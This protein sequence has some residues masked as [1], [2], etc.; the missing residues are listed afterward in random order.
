MKNNKSL[1]WGLIGLAV[2]ILVALYAY[3]ED[4]KRRLAE[5][6]TTEEQKAATPE[7]TEETE[8]AVIPAEQPADETAAA[9]E[10]SAAD[11]T[12]SST[13]DTGDTDS[14]AASTD[15]AEPDETDSTAAQTEAADETDKAEDTLADSDAAETAAASAAPAEP[16]AAPQ[17]D[18]V[19]VEPDGSTVIAG[20]AK[21][22]ATVEVVT[23]DR[24]L[25]ESEV[26]QSG[27]FAAIFDDP[28]APGDYEI[29]LRV[30]EEGDV[31]AQSEEVA[32]V[33][34]P[35]ENPEQLL[36]I[37]TKPGEASRILTQPEA[38]ETASATGKQP[39]A[40]A[41]EAKE[42]EVDTAAV[43]SADTGSKDDGSAPAKLSAD[44]SAHETKTTSAKTDAE[45][46]LSS[47]EAEAA[48]DTVEAV[49]TDPVTPSADS[50]SQVAA[51]ADT[52]EP[53]DSKTAQVPEKAGQP[54]PP[55]DSGSAASESAAV[56]DTANEAAAVAKLRIDAVEIEGGRI[57]VAGSATPGASVRVYADGSAIGDSPVSDTGR[58]LVEAERDISVGQHTISA[59]LMMPGTDAAIM[60]VAVPFTRPAGE[61]VAAV[62]APATSDVSEKMAAGTPQDEADK[63]AERTA[64]ATTEATAPA[65]STATD[66]SDRTENTVTVKSETVAPANDAT[67]DVPKDQQTGETAMTETTELHD[68]SKEAMAAETKPENM[69]PVAETE[70]ADSEA[71]PTPAET[72]T[73]AQSDRTTEKESSSSGA[74]SS[75]D[76]VAEEPGQQKTT[77]MAAQ[78]QAADMQDTADSAPATSSQGTQ[79]AAADTQSPE[80]ETVVQ[81]ALEAKEGSVIIRRG[82][83]LW[84][85]SRRVYGRGVR[86]T[87]IY[88]AN[89]DQISNPDFIEPGQIFMVP[90][91]P[92]S[93]AEQLH[94]ERIKRR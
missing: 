46:P 12:E 94:R 13:S 76:T 6:E 43:S 71:S 88:L 90:D 20:Q 32:T 15:A 7:K 9:G 35:E 66:P 50:G 82:D 75:A 92:L 42:A 34:V 78:S 22:G 16:V 45:K 29:V 55:A 60:R 26:G 69:S 63:P 83:T 19:R 48:S 17:F 59:D 11:S 52:D 58:F 47:E 86:Y 68:A 8:T 64:I 30:V 85:I 79:M 10:D 84:Q 65:P 51:L 67:A 73:N 53:A 14:A 4:Q 39:V 57:F 89:S 18:I 31:V 49:D 38:V 36:V 40:P 21:A 54:A 37:V 56:A 5:A 27:D 3:N 74:S 23:G 41:A 44:T 33:S 72:A 62:A 81:E 2:I 70:M 28:L 80:P 24:V 77:D 91:E 93:N 61:S 1:V 87:T 25:A